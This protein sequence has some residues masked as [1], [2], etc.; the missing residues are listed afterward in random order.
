[1][2]DTL[3][4]ASFYIPDAFE[5]Q[6]VRLPDGLIRA[7]LSLEARVVFA[8]RSS[9]FQQEGRPPSR[10][11]L[12]AELGIGIHQL[13]RL[14]A[15]LQQKGWWAKAEIRPSRNYFVLPHQLLRDSH[16][17]PRSK[18]VALVLANC[19]DSYGRSEVSFAALEKRLGLTRQSLHDQLRGLANYVQVEAGADPTLG[20]QRE[21]LNAYLVRN[22]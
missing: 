3:L 7:A 20:G 11:A 12:R 16:V 10:R 13:Q 4:S 18:A 5:P 1:M 21:Q 9:H 2:T 19:A 17:R 14:C 15:E 22:L 8:L 6:G